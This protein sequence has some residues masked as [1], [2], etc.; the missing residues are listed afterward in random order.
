MSLQSHRLLRVIDSLSTLVRGFANLAIN[1]GKL[2][3]N[4]AAA[5]QPVRRA[6]HA[7]LPTIFSRPTAARIASP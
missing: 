3:A 7:T 4:T 5:R 6:T 1:S 2:V